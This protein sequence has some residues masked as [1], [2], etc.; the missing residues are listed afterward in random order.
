[1]AIGE[2][3]ASALQA[4]ATK[5]HVP[6]AAAGMLVGDDCFT[7]AHGVAN[8]EYPSPVTPAS[9]FQVGSITKTLTSAA[10]MLLVQEG[11]LSLDDPVARYLPALGPATG[12]DFDAITVERALS[13]Q[14]GFDGDHLFVSREWDDLTV[15]KGARR[16]FPPG[17]GYSYN[18]AGFSIAGAIVADLSGQSFESF[19]TER[20]LRPLG[21]TSACFTA[22]R[23]ITYPV[24]APHWVNGEKAYVI[25]GAGWQPGWE[26]GPVDR[27]A[28]GLVASVEHLMTWCRFQT[29]GTALDRSVILSRE[30][31]DRLHTPVVRANLLEE[32]ALDWFA[33]RFDEVTAIGHGGLT[34]G[35]A[36]ELVVVPERD[37]AFVGLTNGT[38]GGLVN[39]EMRRWAYQRFAGIEERD[40]EPDPSVAID[41]A[42]VTGQYVHAFAL[43]T[44]T[45]GSAP[46]TIVIT[47]SKREDIDGWQPPP[48][49][50]FTL[51]FFAEDHAVSTSPPGSPR[52]ARFGFDD[53][54]RAAWILWGGRR[55]PRV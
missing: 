28:G 30:S 51:G 34:A 26:L 14:G 54:G 17:S 44:V 4:A 48:D 37:F 23:A 13:H 47:A 53:E 3:L 32:I 24:A 12:L 39:D 6:G 35:Y 42:R 41:C 40:P 15:L 18:N 31:L 16:L 46:G 10:V 36:S 49:P 52:V 55:A 33:R 5:H 45:P 11:L 8:V 1:M 20:L 29:T 38:N 25:R 43:L 19:V 7:A 27:P 50:P 21:M 2:E 9:L 22:D